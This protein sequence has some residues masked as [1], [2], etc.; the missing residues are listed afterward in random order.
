MDKFK[1]VEQF[2]VKRDKS[3]QDDHYCCE[4]ISPP[5]FLSIHSKGLVDLINT[6]TGQ[7]H[8]FPSIYC[9]VEYIEAMVKVIYLPIDKSALKCPESTFI[10]V[11]MEDIIKDPVSSSKMYSLQQAKEKATLLTS[12]SSSGH[13][14][15]EVNGFF[16]R[17]D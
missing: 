6:V 1:N 14:L 2:K 7:S 16:C 10:L 15:A 13:Y 17:N 12:G 4:I 3:K 9:A 8:N 5:V 11:R